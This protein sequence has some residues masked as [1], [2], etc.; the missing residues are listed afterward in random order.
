MGSNHLKLINIPLLSKIYLN[1]LQYE[2]LKVYCKDASNES[3][4]MCGCAR[5]SRYFFVTQKQA[6][7]LKRMPA[8][9]LIHGS[10]NKL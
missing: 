2:L 8:F 7:I 1:P 3:N 6:S 10:Y 4:E 5:M 9:C